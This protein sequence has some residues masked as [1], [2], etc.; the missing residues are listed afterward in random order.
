MSEEKKLKLILGSSSKFRK[1]LLR[2]FGYENFETM[3]P[4]IDEKAIRHADPST[5]VKMISNGKMDALIGKVRCA[6]ACVCILS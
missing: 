4:D 5:M 6:C 2:G 1:A 3:N